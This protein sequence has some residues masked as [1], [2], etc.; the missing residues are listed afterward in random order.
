[1]ATA[2]SVKAN[3]QN[4]IAKANGKTGRTDDNVDSAVDALISG[5]GQGGGITPTGTKSI[6]TNGEHDVTSFAK[7]N[8]NVPIPSGYIKPSG[9]KSITTNG[10]HDVTNYASAQVNV[11]TGI[12]PS[13]SKTITENGTHDVTN[14]ANAVVNVPTPEQITVVRTVTIQ[15][16]ITGANNTTTLLS[17][18]D[19][20]KK[21]YADEGFSATLLPITAIAAAA[22]VVTFNYHGNRNI[23]ASGISRTG[24]GIRC[25]SASAMTPV[26]QTTAIKGKGYAQHMR[27]DSSGNL[28]QYL[29]SG[30]ILKAG[31]YQ[32]ILTCTT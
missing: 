8:V 1:M 32:I 18:D 15:S 20:I 14:Y 25:T 2:D 28:L 27:V 13:G 23:C 9:T 31:T 4:I 26:N 12:T 16:D 10:T 21:H 7:A 29:S 3:L 19:F 30:Y 22:N 17:G 5:F 6:T 11:P 24:V